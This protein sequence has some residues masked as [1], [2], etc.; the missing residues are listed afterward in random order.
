MVLANNLHSFT[1]WMRLDP[2][3]NRSARL[4]CSFTFRGDFKNMKFSG[5][6][7]KT[8]S[9]LAEAGNTYVAL[10]KV[11]NLFFSQNDMLV[12][13]YSPWHEM[14]TVFSRSHSSLFICQHHS[15]AS[16]VENLLILLSYRYFRLYDRGG[17]NQKSRQPFAF[18]NQRRRTVSHPSWGKHNCS[19]P[20]GTHRLHHLLG[21]YSANSGRAKL[22]RGVP[23][24]VCVVVK[25]SDLIFAK[26]STV[27]AYIG[28]P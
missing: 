17:K 25:R 28:T 8:N 15:L 21:H 2:H 11:T 1:F 6:C 26:V 19:W 20:F 12:S 23:C 16:P 3:S 18:Y 14:N 5:I 27:L 13:L 10:W 9:R 22:P 24:L 4:T 7:T